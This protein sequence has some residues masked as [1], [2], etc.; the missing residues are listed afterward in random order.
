[1]TARCSVITDER[2][3]YHDLP[4]HPESQ[5][6]L[7]VALSGVEKDIP[8]HHARPAAVD[9]LRRVHPD[10]YIEEV[11]RSC[12][13]CPD[14]EVRLLD[15]DTYITRQS[16]EAALAAAGAAIGAVHRALDGEHCFALVRPPGH[17]A[18]PGRPMGFCLFNN[19]AIAATA[20]LERVDRV[21]IVDWDVHHGNGTQYITY[22][23]DR[24]LY[25]SV[26]QRGI[27]PGTGMPYERGAGAGEGYTFNAPLPQGSAIGD[28]LLIF[29]EVFAP[30]LE[31][32]R[33]EAVIVSAGQDPLYDDALGGMML[34]PRD[35]GT[36]AGI[37]ADAVE[38]PLALTLEGG[39]SPS[40]GE[41]VGA[42]IAAL[43]GRRE[44]PGAAAPMPETRRIAGLLRQT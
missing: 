38:V 14:G 40:Q 16:F 35:F 44:S 27:F 23:S 31:R 25:A 5:A 42:V 19:A 6:R 20:A 18:L 26:H 4:L 10:G 2:C 12:L 32:F 29:T 30:E 37:V 3:R 41:A 7:E 34:R 28:Y 17:H 11:R 36:L 22:H 39:Y 8:R 21:A 9:D 43:C 15:P 1:M 13:R 33:P 24:I